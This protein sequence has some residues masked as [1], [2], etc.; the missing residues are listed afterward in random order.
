[1]QEPFRGLIPFC[2]GARV[3]MA[4]RDAERGQEAV[5][6]VIDGSQNTNVVYMKLDLSDTK[7]IREFAEAVNQGMD[8]SRDRS[9]CWW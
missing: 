3:I 4:C 1:M 2:A 7:S 6:E 8:R 9:S 5:K